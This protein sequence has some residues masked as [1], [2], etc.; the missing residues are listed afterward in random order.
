MMTIDVALADGDE[1]G[2]GPVWDAAND[3]LLRVDISCGRILSLD[4][5][6]GEQ[7]VVH[8]A[9][10]PIGFAIPRRTGGVV[11]GVGRSV[12]LLSDDGGEEVLA[13]LEPDRI[14]N[15]L[16]DAR[17]DSAGRLWVG[18]LNLRREPG[19]AALYCVAPDGEVLHRVPGATISNGK[20][21]NGAGDRLYYADSLTQ[22]IDVFDV[23][24]ETGT[25]TDRRRFAEIAAEDGLP[26]GIV[27]DAEEGVW[28]AL[29]GGGALRRYDADGALDEVVTLP[30]S[31]PTSMAFGGPALEDLYVTTARHLLTT[32]QRDAQPLA[33]AVL[34]V[35]PGVSGR[36]AHR[37]GG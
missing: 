28:V 31:N 15:R 19:T 5:A 25:L 14:E 32:E 29:F 22:R 10:A 4:L 12:V 27:V 35:R 17:C 7:G 20:D 23:D 11:A 6:T 16:N 8:E 33:G 26:D 36:P 9:D 1:L 13:S 34:H 37:F 30:T 2:E 24:V 18:S 3:R 21:W